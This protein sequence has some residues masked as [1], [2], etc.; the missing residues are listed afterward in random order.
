MTASFAQLQPARTGPAPAAA[1]T[2]AIV[3]GISVL[4]LM[5][6]GITFFALAVAFPIA[7][8][9]AEAYNLPVSA[10][11]IVLAARFAELS[12]AFAALAFASFA[13]AI[14]VIVKVISFVSPAPRD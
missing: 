8:P 1:V 2:A 6:I 10:T 14:L 9:V 3:G 5:V 12:W 11:D 7:V 13:S 4:T